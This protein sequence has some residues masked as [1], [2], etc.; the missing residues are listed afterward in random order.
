MQFCSFSVVLVLQPFRL[1]RCSRHPAVSAQWRYL[2]ERMKQP[3]S[4]RTEESFFAPKLPGQADDKRNFSRTWSKDRK[5]LQ[6]SRKQLPKLKGLDASTGTIA[7]QST[8]SLPGTARSRSTGSRGFE[9]RPAKPSPKAGSRQPSREPS[10]PH[11][12]PPKE[13]SKATEKVPKR[14]PPKP[15]APRSEKPHSADEARVER[16]E[17][18]EQRKPR[19]KPN[20][21]S[22]ASLASLSSALSGAGDDSEPER[23]A[24]LVSV[25]SRGPAVHGG[26]RARNSPNALAFLFFLQCLPC[27][28]HA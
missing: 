19:P 3:H 17:R 24:S 15:E 4:A 28:A 25:S 8:S 9:E 26:S 1:L 21:A 10:A 7:S 22:T 20:Q 5:R 27:F 14:L 2:L 11:G 16:A 13:P 18:S 23:E 12:R 6:G